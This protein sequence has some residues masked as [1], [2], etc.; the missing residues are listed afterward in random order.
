[1]QKNKKRSRPPWYVSAFNQSYLKRYQHRSEDAARAEVNFA[2]SKLNLPNGAVILDL[3]CGA[4][5]HSRALAAR[6]FNVVAI[7]LSADLLKEAARQPRS[8]RGT[9]KY[10]RADMRRL[11]IPDHMIDGAISMFT[12]FGYFPNDE[13]N[14]RVL[15]EVSRVLKPG[16]SFLMDYFNITATLKTLVP[17]SEKN[18]DGIQ[19]LEKRRY[20]SKNK[21]LIKTI[22]AV[23]GNRT[24]TFRESVRAYSLSELKALFKTAGLTIKTVFG[25][26]SGAPF[27]ASSS[28]RCVLL[29]TK[30]NASRSLAGRTQRKG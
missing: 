13:Q 6:G 1:M 28:P 26:L 12:S 7:D 2:L 30:P 9:I 11:P 3:C 15:R 22:R 5:R 16:A 25:N 21:R 8:S 23:H 29:A 4:G 10:V 20:D 18:I 17:E 19:L 14:I 27:H 24:E